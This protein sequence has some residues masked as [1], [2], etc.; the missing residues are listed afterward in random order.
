MTRRTL[1]LSSAAA[2][3]A[4]RLTPKQRIDRVLKGQDV[5]R[6]PYTYWYH[7][8]LEKLPGAHHARATLDFHRRFRTDLVKV[9]SDY[10][11]PRPAGT[12]YKLRVNTTP[13]PEQLRALAIIDQALRGRVYFVETIFNPWNVAEKLSSKEEVLRLKAEDPTALLQ[14][15]QAI[16]ESEA[17]HAKKAVSAGAAGVFL[18]IANA[19]EGVLTE[20]EY[21]R[22]SEPFDKLVLNAVG[23]A[24][25]NIL[26]LHGERVYLDRFTSGWA[27]T[28]INYS[29]HATGTPLAAMRE[30]YAGVLIGGVDERN[31]RTLEEAELGE[32]RRAA[33]EAAGKRLILAP[34]C[35]VPNETAD[36]ELLR[37]TKIVGA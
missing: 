10:A 2:L 35:S 7:F 18:A 34:G 27:A 28:A 11:F 36:A 30:R 8:G 13:F 25:L 12:W 3:A 20:E 1:L 33:E 4:P 23:S 37:L 6:I 9:M 32:Q 16:A 19:Q 14:A 26:H 31:F 29:A 5:D 21:A 15:L 24:P 22:F 17:A